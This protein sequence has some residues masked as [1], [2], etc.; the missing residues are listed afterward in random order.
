MCGIAG[1]YAF[2]RRTAPPSLDE[3][4]AISWRQR[5]RGPDDHGV[6]RSFDD[7]CLFDHRRLSIIDPTPAGHQPMIDDSADL[8]ITF[9]G[10]I[11]NY[12]D[13]RTELELAG[14]T[15]VSGTDTEVLLKLYRRHGPGLLERLRGMYALAIWDGRRRGVFAARDPLGIKPFYYSTTDGTF[16]FASQARALIAGGGV[17]SA[18]RPGAEAGFLIWG[19]VPEPLTWWSDVSA[20]P[21]GHWLWVDADG[22]SVPQRY[23]D[24]AALFETSIDGGRP[25]AEY[26]AESVGRHLVADVPV[27][28]FLS[29]GLDSM[30]IASLANERMRDRLCSV[31]VAFDTPN[32]PFCD[33]TA[34]VEK[35]ARRLG[36]R[37]RSVRF[38][39]SDFVR[40]RSAILE[41]MDQPTIDGI[42]TYFVSMAAKEVGLKVALSGVGGDELLGGYASFRQIPNLVRV[43]RRFR[44]FRGAGRAMRSAIAPVMSRLASPKYSSL[45]EYGTEIAD[46]YMLRRALFLPWELGAIMGRERARHALEDLDRSAPPIGL[47]AVGAHA[48]VTL[49]EL[50]RYMTNQLLRDTDWAS[51]RHGVE[52]R[53]PFADASLVSELIPQIVSAEPPSKKSLRDAIDDATWGEL[54]ALPKRGFEVPI[55][56]WLRTASSPRG[57]M[58]GLRGWALE[59]M[60]SFLAERTSDARGVASG[61]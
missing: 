45:L 12:R 37:H 4:Q 60:D 58:R 7:R 15:F 44:P 23:F 51:M 61:H 21:A 3:L 28:I 50:R 17:S 8:C 35:V 41:A 47:P 22:P 9:N 38:A 31:T 34:E 20:L 25:V 33:E 39:A 32:G 6:W 14:E 16:R 48:L 42:N 5:F 56:T 53:V 59:V 1:L 26:L 2:N 19:S 27:G 52:V 40:Q 43:L 55:S 10:E 30:A 49:L 29:S 54:A 11:Y 18:V 46:A 24:L 57:R 36:L 13:L